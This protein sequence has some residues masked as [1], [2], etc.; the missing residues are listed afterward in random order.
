MLIAAPPFSQVVL[1]STKPRSAAFGGPYRSRL[2]AYSSA[3]TASC[4][5]MRG[6]QSAVNQSPPHAEKKLAHQ[7]WLS[8]RRVRGKKPA[9]GVPP[10]STLLSFVAYWAISSYVAGG[11]DGSSPAAW[12]ASGR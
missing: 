8:A 5:S 1:T 12:N 9:T 11:L 10:T 3:A 2:T 7:V 4:E 6:F